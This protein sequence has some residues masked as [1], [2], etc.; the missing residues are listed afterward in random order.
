VFHTDSGRDVYGGGG[1]HPDYVVEAPKA[2]QLLFRLLR[3]NLIFDY[4]VGYANAHAALAPDFGQGD[5]FLADFKRFLGQR[6][7]ELDDADYAEHAD[8]VRLRLRSQIARIKWGQEA[9]NSILAAADPQVQ[10]ALAVFDEASQLAMR[11]EHARAL[12]EEEQSRRSRDASA[13]L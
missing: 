12:R 5:E 3:E 13:A 6:G 9:E 11:A 2:P 4:A 8:V 7:F 10:K 1:I